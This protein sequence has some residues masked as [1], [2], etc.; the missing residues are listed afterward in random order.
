MIKTST[1]NDATANANCIFDNIPKKTKAKVLTYGTEITAQKG[2]I[3]FFEGD[4]PDHLYFIKEGKIRLTKLSE[5]GKVFFLQTKKSQD[6]LGELNLF[7]GFTHRFDAEVVQDCKLLR[8]DRKEIENLLAKDTDL[9]ACLLKILSIEN[10]TL[11]HQFRDLIFCGK[12][13]AVFAML[14]RLSNEYGKKISTGILIN[15]KVTNQELANF[16][17]AT[18]ESINRILKRLI[19]QK[20]ISVNTKYITIHDID[21]LKEHLRCAHCPFEECTI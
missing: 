18:R 4:S 9:A 12:Q 2:N 17:G 15:R 7:N 3:I 5:D 21:F 14:I 11:L 10:Q 1:I 20:I 16:V 13:G 19:R 6:L 8:F